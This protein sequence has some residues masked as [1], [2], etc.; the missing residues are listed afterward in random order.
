MADLAA[1]A[2]DTCAP[3]HDSR[4]PG[5]YSGYGVKTLPGIRASDLPNSVARSRGATGDPSLNPVASAFRRNVTPIALVFV[6]LFLPPK[7]GNYM[8]LIANR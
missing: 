1:S 3:E 7:G 4:A 2:T 5:F 8:S 6:A